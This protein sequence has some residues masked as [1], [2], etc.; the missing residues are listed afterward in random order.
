MLMKKAASNAQDEH[1]LKLP[2]QG[3]ID[4]YDFLTHGDSNF[5]LLSVTD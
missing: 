4:A 2:A 5:T 3:E 1:L